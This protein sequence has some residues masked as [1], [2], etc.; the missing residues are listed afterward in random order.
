MSLPRRITVAEIL[1][2][3][4]TPGQRP[5]SWDERASGLEQ[6]TT[7]EGETITI[8]SSG[9]QSTPAPGWELL[10]TEFAQ[11]SPESF[12]WTLYGIRPRH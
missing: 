12:N 9:G 3:R 11:D 5:M 6:L 7:T 2:G 1:D 4:Y 8:F 10:L